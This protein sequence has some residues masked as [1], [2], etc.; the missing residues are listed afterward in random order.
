[1][2]ISKH[3]Q[4]PKATEK[5]TTTTQTAQNWL[6]EQDTNNVPGK[7]QT[8]HIRTYKQQQTNRNNIL[9]E[10]S[11][12]PGDTGQRGTYAFKLYTPLINKTPNCLF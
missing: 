5:K 9:L 4:M 10:T 3:S 2:R 1:M 7:R 12:M 11:I 8:A 6:T